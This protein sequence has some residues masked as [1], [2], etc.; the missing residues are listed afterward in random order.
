MTNSGIKTMAILDA[1]YQEFAEV[2]REQRKTDSRTGEYVRLM[3]SDFK[4]ILR[5]NEII[6][7]PRTVKLKW[8]LLTDIGIFAAS[9]KI[10]AVVDLFAFE[11]YKPGYELIVETGCTHTLTHTSDT[12]EEGCE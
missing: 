4:R 12:T 1:L 10:S 7:D 3:Y 5:K 9:N 11:N 2:W 6:I 8:E